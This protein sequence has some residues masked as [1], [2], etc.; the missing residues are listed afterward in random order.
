MNQF[1]RAAQDYFDPRDP[2]PTCDICDEPWATS[3]EDADDWNGET[4]CH[5]TCEERQK[6]EEDDEPRPCKYGCSYG[7]PEHEMRLLEWER[8]GTW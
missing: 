5:L 8:T 7:S 1:D 6:D 3:Y 4:G 2:E